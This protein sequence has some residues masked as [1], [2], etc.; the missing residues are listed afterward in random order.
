MADQD[1]SSRPSAPILAINQSKRDEESAETVQLRKLKTRKRMKRLAY[2]S[3]FMVVLIVIILIISL[4]LLRADSP[5][6]R[7]NSITIQDLI[8]NNSD[9]ESP[10]VNMRLG[11]EIAVK[12]TNFW[13]FKFEDR[14]SNII[15]FVYEDNLVGNITL[16]G[17]GKA[18]ARSTKK[19]NVT[20]NV[21]AIA[22]SELEGD[23]ESGSL[24]MK[25]EGK[26]RGK[27]HLLGFIKMKRTAQMN[28]TMTIHLEDK[29]V[30]DL[31]CK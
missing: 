26:L 22:N 28:C 25:S 1:S 11:A 14:S 12:N 3:V 19:M 17:K 29:V 10:S 8:I 24:S 2:V 31:E 18:K 16:V 27:V 21:S 7:I 30:Q 20:G 9:S 13:E 15:S 6:F 23:I 4:T 5:K